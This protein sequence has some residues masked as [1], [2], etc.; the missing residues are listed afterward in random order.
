[1]SRGG[2]KWGGGQ[3]D[4]PLGMMVHLR[5]EDDPPLEVMVG[6]EM[7]PPPQSELRPLLRDGGSA[8]SSFVRS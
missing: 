7:Y 6:I 2:I 3:A 1:M 5:G 8:F 4:P